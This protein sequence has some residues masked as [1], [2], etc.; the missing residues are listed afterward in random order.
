MHDRIN[1]DQESDRLLVHWD[2]LEPAP[3]SPGIAGGVVALGRSGEPGSLDG[4][5]L[6]V[7]VPEDVE[8]L[9]RHDPAAARRWRAAVRDTL[10]ALLADGAR[11]AGFD[12]AGWYVLRR[13]S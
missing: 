7:A 10:T 11:F 2:L 13:P 12:R 3:P 9:R 6:L 1:G 4:E 5:K 8:T